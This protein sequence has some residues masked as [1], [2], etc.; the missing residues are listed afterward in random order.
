[1]AERMELQYET[2][3]WVFRGIALALVGSMVLIGAA[4]TFL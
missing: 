2:A 1:M 3:M 4:V